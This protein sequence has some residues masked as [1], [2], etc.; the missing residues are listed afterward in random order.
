MFRCTECGHEDD[1]DRNAAIEIRRRGLAALGLDLGDDPLPP[2]G[3]VGEARGAL[4]TSMA[5]NRE[6]K[7][8]GI[9]RRKD[10][11]APQ[12]AVSPMALA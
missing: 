4:C 9:S 11:R 2:A 12:S 5:V 1:A 10:R 6:K 8:D 3:T 7:N